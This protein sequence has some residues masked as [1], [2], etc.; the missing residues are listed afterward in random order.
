MGIFPFSG[1]RQTAGSNLNKLSDE[2]PRKSLLLRLRQPQ[3]PFVNVAIA[4]ARPFAPAGIISERVPDS[5]NPEPPD[6]TKISP[7]A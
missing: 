3:S 5:L 7:T 2:L 1:R 6:S 4:F